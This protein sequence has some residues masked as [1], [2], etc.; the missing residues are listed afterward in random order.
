MAV[1]VSGGL[2]RIRRDSNCS[3]LVGRNS[4]SLPSTRSAS[5]ASTSQD[6]ALGLAPG[7]FT[8][9]AAT[10]P[11]TVDDVEKLYREEIDVLAAQGLSPE[12]FERSKK[13][14]LAQLG[15]QKQ[16]LESYCHSLA[17]NQLYGFSLDYLD[18]RQRQ[19]EQMTVQDVLGVC[20]KYLMD[21]PATTVIVKA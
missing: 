9:Y 18:Q 15:F 21:K 3:S 8:L 10:A 7:L 13:K 20:H 12:E 4:R 1:V 17:L 6:V 11:E 14:L 5:K 2:Y 16:N 19:I